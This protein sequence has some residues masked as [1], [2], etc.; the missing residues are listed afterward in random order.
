MAS[1]ADTPEARLA[2]AGFSLPP[3]PKPVATYVT[4]VRTGN[5]L[6]LSGHGECGENYT[7]GKV[8]RD[9]T[10][11]Q[12]RQSAEKVGLCMLATIKAAVGE[13]SRVKRFVRILGMVNATE[14]FKDHPKVVNGFSDLMVIAFGDAGKAARSAV[15]MQSLPSDIAVEIEATVELHDGA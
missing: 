13:L 14:D 1:D 5:L 4:S 7:R 3:P 8:G 10:I 2:A 15:G 11:E 6:F 9:L 12:G